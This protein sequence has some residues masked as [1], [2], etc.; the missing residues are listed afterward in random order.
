MLRP[1]VLDTNQ[2]ETETNFPADRLQVAVVLRFAGE[3]VSQRVHEAL[4]PTNRAA[5]R[6]VVYLHETPETE[7]RMN[8]RSAFTIIH[9]LVPGFQMVLLDAMESGSIPVIVSDDFLP[10]FHEVLDWSRFSLRIAK[11]NLPQLARILESIPPAQ[12]NEM[13]LNARRKI[14][15]ATLHVLERRILPVESA[16]FDEW[17][18]ESADH[19][20]LWTNVPIRSL[21]SNLS[22]ILALSSVFV[23]W[24]TASRP[25]GL[26]SLAEQLERPHGQKGRVPVRLL[27]WDAADLPAH[28]ADFSDS[29]EHRADISHDCWLFVDLRTADP[30]R[31]L[32]PDLFRQ[33]FGAWK[34]NADAVLTFEP[35]G[36]SFVHPEALKELDEA[37]GRPPRCSPVALRPT[38]CSARKADD[39]AECAEFRMQLCRPA[40]L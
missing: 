1:Y 40:V 11:Q 9:D 15:L 3:T 21:A 17:T 19:Q 13:R 20:K 39:E 16:E 10:P 28:L 12:V 33:A 22:V 24:P 14:A 35:S 32:T 18:S 26:E 30:L 36:V 23:L 27:N 29:L 8:V 5:N 6:T 37:D 4:K 2:T 31:P 25:A 38:E 34:E 7:H